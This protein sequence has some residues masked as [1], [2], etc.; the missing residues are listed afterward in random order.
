MGADETPREIVCALSPEI[1][2]FRIVLTWGSR[3]KD[4]DAHLS[5]TNPEGNLVIKAGWGV[6]FSTVIES[7]DG[8]KWYFQASGGQGIHS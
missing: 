7:W 6:S 4:L 5:G 1:K 3:P 2:E 8:G